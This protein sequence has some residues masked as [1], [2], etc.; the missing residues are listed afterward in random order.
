[1][2]CSTQDL[3]ELAGSRGTAHFIKKWAGEQQQ[4][5]LKMVDVKRVTGATEY[6]AADS[7]NFVTVFAIECRGLEPVEWMPRADFN[8]TTE[9]GTVFP[10][11]SAR[12]GALFV[13]IKTST[14]RCH[15]ACL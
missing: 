15:A 6:G 8:V 11:V 10:E 3:L 4:T 9:Q 1:L 14:S 13:D 5:Y 2:L 12:A 7:G